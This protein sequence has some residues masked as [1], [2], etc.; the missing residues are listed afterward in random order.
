[1]CIKLCSLINSNYQTETVKI[2]IQILSTHL[3]PNNRNLYFLISINQSDKKEIINLIKLYYQ[4]ATWK[5]III[6]NF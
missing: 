5:L 6:N 2:N 3:R 4:H 1:M